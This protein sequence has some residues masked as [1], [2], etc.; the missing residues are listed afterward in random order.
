[1]RQQGSPRH[2]VRLHVGS[3]DAADGQ[4]EFPVVQQNLIPRP[5]IGR[6]PSVGCRYPAF[7]AGDRLGGDRQ[8]RAGIEVGDPSGNFADPYLRS[9][10]V[11]KNA[12]M[13]RR[14]PHRLPYAG[15][16]EAVI[17]VRPVGEV[18]P[19][20]IHPGLDHPH[21]KV[22]L[23]RRGAERVEDF[24]PGLGFSAHGRALCEASVPVQQARRGPTRPAHRDTRR[25]AA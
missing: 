6:E 22:H 23:P 15:E 2:H 5:H 1:M 4:L 12:D 8:R 7:V 17:V 19:D 13:L 21:E 11:L 10:Q 9:L 20:G 18:E 24:C 14:A 16:E 3:P 25:P